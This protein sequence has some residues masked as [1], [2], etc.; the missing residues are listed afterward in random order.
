MNDL[1]QPHG[2]CAA[3]AER[4]EHTELADLRDK[5]AGIIALCQ[6]YNSPAVNTGAHALARKCI[7]IIRS[8]TGKVI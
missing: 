6:R 5:L 7:A 1:D 4:R 8:D 3:E 2:L